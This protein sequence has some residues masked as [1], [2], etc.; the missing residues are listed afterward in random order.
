M[1]A[2]SSAQIANSPTN[3]SKSKAQYSFAKSERF[4]KPKSSSGVFYDIP[5][6]F[7]KRTT[8]FGYGKKYDFTTAVEKTPDPGAYKTVKELGKDKGFSFGLSRDVCKSYIEGHF[9]ADAC[10]PGPGTYSILPK[11]SNE[12][13]KISMQGK[14]TEVKHHSI[15]PGPGA[16]NQSWD[17]S[18]GK[19][20][21]STAKNLEV[22]VF[23][24]KSSLRFPKEK[25]EKF[26]DSCSYT[27][28]KGF[29]NNGKLLST[30]KSSGSIKFGITEREFNYGIKNTPGPGTY[31][32][33][34]EFGYYENLRI[35]TSRGEK[36]IK[37]S[38]D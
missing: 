38:K 9:K 1:L 24:P 28:D 20:V 22:H 3:N 10:V 30:Y 26:P 16:Y 19:Y 31:R 34:S 14:T 21:H 6:S 17:R 12:G 29:L 25:S 15:V 8:S 13:R 18:T 23:S 32:L 7:D 27:V 35:G 4:L 36:L 11:F 37:M 33:P 5:A 2:S